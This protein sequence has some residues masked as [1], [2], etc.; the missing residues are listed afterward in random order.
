MRMLLWSEII[1]LGGVRQSHLSGRGCGS[2]P[3][4]A[5]TRVVVGGTLAVYVG[6]RKSLVALIDM[7]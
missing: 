7:I 4:V 1:L 6:F 5:R 2:L 3:R